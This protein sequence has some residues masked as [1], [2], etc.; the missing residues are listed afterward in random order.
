[1]SRKLSF[2][3]PKKIKFQCMRC[4]LCCRSTSTR[5][6]HVFALR[7]EVMRIS[8]QLGRPIKFFSKPSSTFEGFSYELRIIKGRCIFLENNHC[9]IY[10]RRPLI[11]RCYP[12]WLEKERYKY[13][14]YF[15]KECPAIGSGSK[16]KKDFFEKLLKQSVKKLETK[17]L[18]PS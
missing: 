9:L 15:S 13:V 5:K 12:F 11:C 4:S 3:Y 1:M 10:S 7:K 17:E 18:N 16:L 14:F 8:D 6:R 2:K